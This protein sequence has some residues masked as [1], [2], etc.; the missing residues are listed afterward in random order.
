MYNH[1]IFFYSLAISQTKLLRAFRAYD[2]SITGENLQL[3]N[4]MSTRHRH[5]LVL[6]QSMWVFKGVLSS[7][8]VFVLNVASHYGLVSDDFLTSKLPIFSAAIS[9]TV[10]GLVRIKFLIGIA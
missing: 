1:A 9:C 2:S 6:V 4:E 5:I 3:L 8:F 10:F 7:Q